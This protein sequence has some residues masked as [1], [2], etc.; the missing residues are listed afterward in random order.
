MARVLVVDD[1]H[2]MRVFLEVLLTRAGHAVEL[3]SNASSAIATIGDRE[4]DV[5]LTDLMLGRGGGGGLDVLSAVKKASPETEVIVMTAYASDESDLS[6]MRMGAYDYVAKPF[7]RND[8]L[9]LLLE[10]ALEKRRLAQRE[11]SLTQDNE[12]LREQ[13]SSKTRFEGMVGRSPA[14]QGVFTLVEKVAASRTTVLIT[15]ESGV[16]KELVARAV[17]AKSPRAS[18]PFLPVNCGAIPE[19]LIESELFGH[20][21]GAFTGAAGAKEGLFQAAHG[22]TLFLDEIGE[23]GLQLQVKLLRAIQERRIRPVGATEDLE[24]D[25]RLV[26]ATNRDLPEEVRAGRFREDLYYRL[27]VVQV[28]VPPLRERREDVLALA[29]HFLKRFGAEHGRSRLRLSPDANRRLDDYPFPGNVRELENLIERAVA[30]S[31]GSEVTVDAL[32]APLRTPA[33]GMAQVS[34]PLPPGFSL[35][36]HLAGVERQLIDRALAESRGVKKDAATRLGLTFRQ[37][38]HRIKKLSGEAEAEGE[39]AEEP[40]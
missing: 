34:G 19:G 7:K 1:E 37:L 32:P 4:F 16:G 17:H 31:T 25:V 5:V 2:S 30:L 27:N 10:K 12:L 26:A 38:R 39:E 14:M 23:L 18:A 21:K 13:L 24:V 28:R 8:E 22:G 33:N 6:A 11:K 9:V 20:V 36:A 3:A 29:E 15:G 35:E 40:A